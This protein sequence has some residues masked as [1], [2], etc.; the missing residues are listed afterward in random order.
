[1]AASEGSSFVFMVD[2]RRK[3][4]GEWRRKLFGVFAFVQDYLL[5]ES[6]HKIQSYTFQQY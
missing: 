4:F 1:M 5:W 3:L 6:S 2:N